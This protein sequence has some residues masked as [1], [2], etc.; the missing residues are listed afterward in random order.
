MSKPSKPSSPVV[1]PRQASRLALAAA[2]A[3]A[4]LALT[5]THTFAQGPGAAFGTCATSGDLCTSLGRVM[6]ASLCWAAAFAATIGLVR[7]RQ[8]GSRRVNPMVLACLLLVV[9]VVV[10]VVTW[11]APDPDLPAVRFE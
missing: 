1:V 8:S 9:F 10:G 7:L 5:G 4:G 11:V 3:L 2:T 6:T